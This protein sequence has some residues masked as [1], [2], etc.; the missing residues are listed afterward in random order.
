MV[1]SV[2]IYTTDYYYTIY[3][4]SHQKKKKKKK[5]KKILGVFYTTRNKMDPSSHQPP[6]SWLWSISSFLGYRLIVMRRVDGLLAWYEMKSWGLAKWPRT[7]DTRLE[8]QQL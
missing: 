5:K 3:T 1:R 2:H 8:K 4:G 7:Y 6:F